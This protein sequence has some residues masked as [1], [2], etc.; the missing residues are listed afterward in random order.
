MRPTDLSRR[1]FLQA[2]AAAGVVAA[3]APLGMARAAVQGGR[4]VPPSGWYD[5]QRAR[6][7]AD[8][9][10]KV[11]GEKTFS[12]DIRA[13]DM[14]GWPDSQS[15]AFLLRAARTDRVF[16][17]I[18]LDPLEPG[19]RPDVLITAEELARDGVAMVEPDFYG[20]LLLRAGTAPVYLGQ[21]LALLVYHDYARFRLAKRR[22]KFNEDGVRY[23]APVQEPDRAP[24][25]GARFVRIGGGT[26]VARD[27]F[28]PLKDTVLFANFDK[29]RSIWPVPD[30]AGDAGQR[31]MAH[32]EALRAELE[33]PP[34]G[35]QVFR[36]RYSS[37]Y[38]D[39]A[40]MEMDNGN[41]WYDEAGERLHVVTGTQSPYTN[42][43][44]ILQ[45]VSDSHF[46]LRELKFHAGY[47]VG[48]GQK[49]HH[50]FPYYVAMAALYGQG[51]PVRLALD[52]WEHFQTALKRHPFDIETTIAVDF[53]TGQ[54]RS[55][56][57]DLEGNG[58]GV[59][60]F[61]PSVGQV[62][63]TA[64]QS[65]YYF[66]QSDLAVKVA[67]TR[68]PAAGSMRGYGTTQSMATT[69]MLVDEIAEALRVDP[70]ELRRRNVFRSGMKN[71][72]GA[73]PAGHLRIDELLEAAG[74]DPL[75]TERRS[76][77]LAYDAAHPGHLYGVG[78][79][80]VQKDYGTGAEAALCQIEIGRDGKVTLRH[81]ASEIGC[82]STTSQMLVPR[83]HL[84]RPADAAEF[85][86][87]DWPDLPLTSNDEPYTMSQEDQDAAK[88]D[89]HWV[90]RITSPR[91]ASN[92]A[93][94]FSHATR[95]AARI[96]FEEGLW[97]AAVS[98][99]SEGIGGGQARPLVVRRE[100]A[101]WRDGQLVAGGLEPLDIG[102]L[103]Q[104][105][106][107]RG[108][109]T[110]VT[111]HTFN[112]WAWATAEFDLP[113][114][115]RLEAPIDALSLRYGDGNAQRQAADLSE[116]GYR[117]LPRRRVSY[118][119]VQRTNAAVVYY[120]PVATMVELAVNAGSGEVTILS[121]KSWME[122][123][124][125]IVPELVS[126]QL[127]GG[128]A[129]GIGHALYED[130]PLY[131]DGPGNGTWNFNRYRLPRARDV[132]VWTQEGQVLPPT[133]RDDPPK[134]IAEVVMIPVIAAIA[135][136]V[137]DATGARFRH[138]P[139]TADRI[140]EAIT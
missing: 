55:L 100:N 35:W 90:P 135:N 133:S 97:R 59:R 61:S 15:H 1:D 74:R 130:M 36:Q 49:E 17:G 56:A 82:G 116:R 114:G 71:T 128:I 79:A 47:T 67:A 22:M 92:S 46:G 93:Y 33:T 132:A 42:A 104:R 2:A 43:N 9:M 112:R 30:E 72:Q 5:G 115:R 111:V 12:I 121:H 52:R 105:A 117:F 62:A 26:P 11:T 122:C 44:H 96:L 78:F 41:A 138:L 20:A 60:N 48:Y 73:I 57:A 68:A 69:E 3:V 109:V 53:E 21:P 23:G 91:S 118:P 94:Y 51:R 124:N 103:A 89:P 58:G 95:E 140:R 107:D 19:L 24:Y 10:G 80:A 31:A 25:G 125:M 64:L 129:M 136:A 32:A 14:P 134:G 102:R 66:P 98:I 86:V 77:K 127:Q 131:E 45:M 7:R 37:Q 18:T 34:E 13:R 106:H 4:F 8:G 39:P 70:I 16:E 120:A 54:F 87:V 28:S 76:A 110:G 137:H 139:L 108:F 63:A 85:A 40:A 27:V 38:I 29:K 6:F 75:W 65:I 123:G 126:G 99:W 101:E 84:G 50:A 88:A 113:G 119:P 81:V 83:D